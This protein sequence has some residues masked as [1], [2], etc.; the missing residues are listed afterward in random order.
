MQNLRQR[1]VETNLAGVRDPEALA[2]LPEPERKE[3]QSLWG[4]V[5]ALLERAQGHPEKAVAAAS[6]MPAKAPEPDPNPTAAAVNPLVAP[7]DLAQS[8]IDQGLTGKAVPLLRTASAA[9]PN[10]TLLSLKV[11]ALQAWF[12]QEKELAATR[13]RI[14]TFAKG[15]ND[16][17]TAACAANGVQYP[18]IYRQ[19]GTRGGARSGSR[20]GEGP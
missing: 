3:W 4:D 14:L 13:Q 11:A 12:G 17:W 16:R 19:G 20:R 10:D 15:T 1:K 8:Y 7:Q 9:D 6:P 18:T 2:K 5:D